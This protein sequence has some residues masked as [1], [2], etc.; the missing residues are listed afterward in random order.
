MEPIILDKLNKD[1]K[2]NDLLKLNSYW[3]KDLNRNSDNYNK[4]VNSMKEKY[5]LKATDKIEEV[6]DNIDIISSILETLK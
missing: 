3:F 6:I 2:M 1:P 4:F 5:H